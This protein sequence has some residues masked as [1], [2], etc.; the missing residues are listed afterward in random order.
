M[1][2][3]RIKKPRLTVGKPKVT[4]G[5]PKVTVGGDLGKAGQRVIRGA[6]RAIEDFSKAPLAAP[7]QVLEVIEG[8][9]VD[10][11]L[12]D[13]LQA[14]LKAGASVADLAAEVNAI[15][16]EIQI[17]LARRAGGGAAADILADVQ[18]VSQPFPPEYAAAALRTLNLF[19]QTGRIVDLNPVALIVAAEIAIARNRLWESARPLPDHVLAALP[20]ELRGRAGVCRHMTA[21]DIPGRTSL[22]RIAINH[23]KRAS[24]VCLYD[25]IVFKQIPSSTN[26]GDLHYWC[27]EL[28][29]AQQYA[30][31][32][33][34]EF[35]SRYV[36]NEF[37][38]GLNPIE[39]DADLYAC[40]FFPKANPHYIGQCPL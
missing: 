4:V 28:H 9:P 27:H 2:K 12:K 26:D 40:N 7:K 25:L 1:V 17:E 30:G 21:S 16:S 37:K 39:E 24:A 8:K 11:A 5:K 15:S 31:W 13:V 20:E 10:K 36:A 32:G 35:A 23:L 29:H 22:P 14:Q 34:Q 3:I 38:G 33:I 6:T 18:R 19:L